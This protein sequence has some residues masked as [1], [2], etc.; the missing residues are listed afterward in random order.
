MFANF[1]KVNNFD[2]KYEYFIST[3]NY[4]K[5]CCIKKYLTSHAMVIF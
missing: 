2:Y 3:A 5:P 4:V 1:F